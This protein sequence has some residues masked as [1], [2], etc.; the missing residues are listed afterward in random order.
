MEDAKSVAATDDVKDDLLSKAAADAVNGDEVKEEVKEEIKEEIKD[1][2]E[3][4]EELDVKE[5]KEGLPAD[6]KERS[7]LGRTLAALHRRLD[8]FDTRD[9]ERSDQID[10]L[11]EALKTKS[12]PEDLDMDEPLTRSELERLLE[13]RDS[14][15][16]E[17]DQ[18]LTKKYHNEY[19][20]TWAG[21]AKDLSDEDYNAIIVEAENMKYDPTENGAVDAT[22][23]FKECQVRYFKK[24]LKTRKNP[25]EDNKPT[26]GTGT[27]TTQK[28]PDRETVLPKL[29]APAQ[30]YL[31]YVSREDGAERATN[32]HKSMAK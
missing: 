16:M 10:R 28:V 7:Q 1:V 30:S 15:K 25:L 20:T 14:Q 23:N 5:D 18:K 27:I 29:D 32:L 2:E 13:Q 17:A 21:M 4:I 8:D 11:V 19:A 6:Q 24:Q 3:K 9:A 22:V 12:E 31:N 26:N